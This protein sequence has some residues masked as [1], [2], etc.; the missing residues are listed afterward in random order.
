LFGVVSILLGMPP[1]LVTALAGVGLVRLVIYGGPPIALAVLAALG[2]LNGAAATV[3]IWT[4]VDSIRCRRWVR[5]VVVALG[6]PTLVTS[7]LMAVGLILCA[8]TYV[9]SGPTADPDEGQPVLLI[10]FLVVFGVLGPVAFI[11]FY[12]LRSV[13]ET[14]AAYDP[15]P[16]WTE[17]TPLP[18]FVGCV[19]L[20]LFGLLTVAMSL[21]GA[22][23]VFGTYVT[24]VAAVVLCIGAGAAMIASGVLMHLGR[25]WAWWMA[26]AV[27]VGGFASAIVTF[28]RLG[29][30]EFYRRGRFNSFTLEEFGRV[31]A[32]SGIT[33]IVFAAVVFAISMGY[34]L[35]MRRSVGPR[36]TL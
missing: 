20:V 15:S 12:T 9:P 23:P 22:V 6:W 29:I 36:E 14:L 16:S 21:V 5:P 3:L 11:V 4:G 33:P 28:C 24:G 32:M 10:A 34:L 26:A 17:A 18:V 2:L 27:V 19:S 31:P 8:A 35:W 1:T 25:A 30:M 7:L 13:R